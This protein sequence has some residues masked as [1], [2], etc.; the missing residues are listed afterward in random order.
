MEE[1]RKYPRFA[2]NVEVHWKKISSAEERTAQHISHVKDVSV[3]GVCIVLHP[4]IVV[5]DVLQ[6]KIIL[7]S[8]KSIHSKGKVMWLDPQ[9]RIKGRT[10]LVCE[11]GV[12][13]VDISDK[14]REEIDLFRALHRSH[15]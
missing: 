8:K 9:S 12:E 7:P 14:D 4:S 5:G 1:R 10:S 11:G 15:K 2:I 13:F 6:L 3:G